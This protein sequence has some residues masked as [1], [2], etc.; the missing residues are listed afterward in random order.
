M[1]RI[2][3]VA[4]SFSNGIQ[5]GNV[6]EQCWPAGQQKRCLAGQGSDRF[7]M[8]KIASSIYEF[9]DDGSIRYFI[10]DGKTLDE[11]KILLQL[12]FLFLIKIGKGML[13]LDFALDIISLQ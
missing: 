9:T 4:L 6:K 13:P 11:N 10:W 3:R 8:P 12:C 2:I 1:Q 5:Q 7:G